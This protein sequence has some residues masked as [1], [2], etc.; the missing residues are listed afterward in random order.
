MHWEGLTSH[1]SWSEKGSVMLPIPSTMNSSR[2]VSAECRQ[3]RFNAPSKMFLI[4]QE[5]VVDPVPRRANLLV[6]RMPVRR[7]G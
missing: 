7:N 5:F 6:R 1:L 4:G 3:S 2:D